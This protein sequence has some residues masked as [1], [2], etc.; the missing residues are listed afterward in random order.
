MQVDSIKI[1]YPNRCE[2]SDG[3]L[4]TIRVPSDAIPTDL[5]RFL[6]APHLSQV[7]PGET[8]EVRDPDV[9]DASHRRAAA[10]NLLQWKLRFRGAYQVSV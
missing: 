7:P 9:G 2:S 4:T 8:C 3:S 6:T 5:N 1:L 10:V